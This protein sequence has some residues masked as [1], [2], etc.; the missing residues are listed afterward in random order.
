MN[1][2][3]TTGTCR[4][5]YVNLFTPRADPSGRER[6]S[7]VILIRK[8]DKKTLDRY[9]ACIDGMLKD[10]DTVHKIGGKK[11][12]DNAHMPL[13]DGDDKGDPNFA[14]CF[15]FNAKANPG[16]PPKVF[17]HAKNDIVDRDEIYS[18]VYAQC[19][20]SFYPYNKS[21]NHGIGCGLRAVRKIKDGKRIGGG[22][23]S[24]RD[25]DDDLLGEDDL[26]DIF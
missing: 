13:L 2:K 4:L 9:Y 22:S 26:N 16:Y 20:L 15:Y 5:C 3:F 21:G 10:E 24:D 12:V 17:D 7:A 8:D 19:V 25:F 11:A 1:M 6:Y 23:F 18:G 14:G